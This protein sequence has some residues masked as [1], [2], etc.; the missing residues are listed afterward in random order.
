MVHTARIIAS[1]LLESYKRNDAPFDAVRLTDDSALRLCARLAADICNYWANETQ[2]KQREMA[3]AENQ[4][5]C[6]VRA[7][8]DRFVSF[9]TV[10]VKPTK[11]ESEQ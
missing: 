1:A 8:S 10:Q 2:L 3:A 11:G 5:F 6:N 9:A 4:S 7:E